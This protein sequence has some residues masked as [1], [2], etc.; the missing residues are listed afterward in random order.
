MPNVPSAGLTDT[1]FPTS[2][3]NAPRASGCYFARQFGF[4]GQSDVGYTDRGGFCH[5]STKLY[6][7]VHLSSDSG[8]TQSSEVGRWV[9]PVELWSIYHSPSL[10]CH[11][12]M[13]RF[14]PLQRIVQVMGGHLD[15]KRLC[16][17]LSENKYYTIW[18]WRRWVHYTALEL[19][20]SPAG[21]L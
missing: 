14:T 4:V 8:G 21:G 9:L 19:M 15:C 13:V 10:I 12:R 7:L 11:P 16:W 20:L 3:V 2:I 5:R 17:Q 6:R 18:L 1:T